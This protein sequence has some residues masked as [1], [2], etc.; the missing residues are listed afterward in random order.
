MKIIVVEDEPRIRE[1]VVNMLNKHTKHEVL[2]AFDCAERALPVII[3]K[4]PDLVISDI[5]MAEMDGLTLLERIQE[6]GLQTASVLLTGYADFE[7][8]RRAIQVK[9]N[10]YLLKPLTIEE[11]LSSLEKVEEKLNADFRQSE[12]N[13]DMKL[14]AVL[15]RAMTCGGVDW[16][17]LQP[18]IEMSYGVKLEAEHTMSFFQLLSVDHE[19]YRWVSNRLRSKIKSLFIENSIILEVS[20]CFICLILDSGRNQH[21]ERML[22]RYV[23]SEI[24]SSVS[25]CCSSLRFTGFDQLR[26]VYES[27]RKL[28]AYQLLK[29]DGEMITQS[30]VDSLGRQALPYPAALE[31]KLKLA[32][33]GRDYNALA[34]LET[35]LLSWLQAQCYHPDEIKSVSSHLLCSLCAL[36]EDVEPRL[37]GRF[38]YSEIVSRIERSYTAAELLGVVRSTI[39]RLSHKNPQPNQIPNLLV[40]RAIQEIAGQ[41]QTS[42]RLSGVAQRL[43]ITPEYLSSLFRKE[44]G[45][46]F[47]TFLRNFRLSHAKR[48]LRQSDVKIQEVAEACG[49]RD[50]QYFSRIFKEVFALSPNEYR[51]QHFHEEQTDFSMTTAEDGGMYETGN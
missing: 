14:E 36:A 31:E 50:P 47:S 48:L 16:E 21:L 27:C 40:S 32:I 33:Y 41:Y 8:A 35:E 12:E 39:E 51:Q 1:G 43:H 26:E 20:N 23:L 30:W 22:E 49:F 45:I 24:H 25:C 13:L 37:A 44:M 38:H 3:E 9:A 42:M 5:R 17:P 6:A 15:I 34:C 4:K 29:A 10:D 2:Q 18:T 46:N 7:Y 28:T 19:S 11:L